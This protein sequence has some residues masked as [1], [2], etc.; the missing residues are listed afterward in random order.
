M[1]RRMGADRTV[2]AAACRTGRHSSLQ[3]VFMCK[4][5]SGLFRSATI[6]PTARALGAGWKELGV[7]M[8]EVRARL[9][10][11]IVLTMDYGLDRL[12]RVLSAVASAGRADQR[13]DALRQ[14]SR[15][16]SGAVSRPDHVCLPWRLPGIPLIRQR[17]TTVDLAAT[18]T[19]A[20]HGV[21]IQDYQIYSLSGPIGPP[22]DPP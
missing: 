14:R 2:V 20:R 8:D 11:P 16:G 19:R 15:T 21:P 7:Q 9:G 22:L 6:D 4:P 12:A 10:A 1:E 13:A 3:P 5:P 17:F 18:L